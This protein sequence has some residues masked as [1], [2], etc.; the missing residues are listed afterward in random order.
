MFR[1]NFSYEVSCKVFLCSTPGSWLGSFCVTWHSLGNRTVTCVPQIPAS[2]LAWTPFHEQEKRSIRSHTRQMIQMVSLQ[3]HHL[4]DCGYSNLSLHF[5]WEAMPFWHTTP[6]PLG[7]ITPF[8]PEVPQMAKTIRLY[9]QFPA[10]AGFLVPRNSLG[11]LLLQNIHAEYLLP[12]QREQMW[13]QKG[14]FNWV[15]VLLPT[16]GFIC[17]LR[18]VQVFWPIS[19]WGCGGEVVG[20]IHWHS[21]KPTHDWMSI[22]PEKEGLCLGMFLRGSGKKTSSLRTT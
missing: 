8:Q 16:G 11:S 15:Q 19:C 12:Q 18:S 10:W 2:L 4:S 14:T 9:A 1:R 21:P 17:V 6:V 22:Q 3:S 20:H 7:E 5:C 13:T